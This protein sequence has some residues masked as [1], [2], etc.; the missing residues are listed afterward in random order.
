MIA[1]MGKG[2][3]LEISCQLEH[4]VLALGV[5]LI[6]EL[7]CSEDMNVSRMQFCSVRRC[8]RCYSA[9]ITLRNKLATESITK[10]FTSIECMLSSSSFSLDSHGSTVKMSVPTLI[11]VLRDCILIRRYVLGDEFTQRVYFHDPNTLHDCLRHQLHICI[12]VHTPTLHSSCCNLEHSVSM[13]LKPTTSRIFISDWCS[14][15]Q[16]YM[17]RSLERAT[18]TV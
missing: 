13:H 12:G 17:H 18:R 11:K 10:S 16:L 6:I 7:W 14:N 3:S 15:R 1:R 8:W 9:E 4:L 5:C 2:I